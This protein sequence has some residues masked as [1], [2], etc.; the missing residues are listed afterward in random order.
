M[1][2][3]KVTFV[4]AVVWI[5]AISLFGCTIIGTLAHELLHGEAARGRTVI[6]VD[7]DGT[8]LTEAGQ[9]F[10]AHSHLQVYALEG[11][12]T[13][14]LITITGLCIAIIIV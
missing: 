11:V 14:F 4:V 2:G 1:I 5:V 12:V 3:K 9:G 8:G 13:A 7:Y 10:Y 6:T